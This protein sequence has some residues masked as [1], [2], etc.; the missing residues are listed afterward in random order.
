MVWK[1]R[2]QFPHWLACYSAP[3]YF[4]VIVSAHLF[5]IT[6]ICIGKFNTNR[7]ITHKKLPLMECYHTFSISGGVYLA[8]NHYDNYSP[9]MVPVTPNLGVWLMDYNKKIVVYLYFFFTLKMF[10]MWW[11]MWHFELWTDILTNIN[12]LKTKLFLDYQKCY[13][14]NTNVSLWG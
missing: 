4:R 3:I 11:R 6:K 8:K 10:Q 13:N 12:N 1:I 7:V 14:M 5:F 9:Q 2:V